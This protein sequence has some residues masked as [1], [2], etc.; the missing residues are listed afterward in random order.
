MFA[1]TTVLSR[2]RAYRILLGSALGLG[3]VGVTRVWWAGLGLWKDEAGIANNL[4]RSYLALTGHLTYE[5]VA[6]VGWLW[7][8][9][10][11]LEVLGADDRVIRLPSYLGAL[12]V[13]CL[14]TLIAHRVIGRAGAVVVAGLLAWSPTLLVYSG[15]LKQYTW[16]A[17]VALALLLLGAWAHQAIRWTRPISRRG[18]LASVAWVAATGVAVFVSYSAILVTAAVTAAVV[19]MHALRRSWA[20]VAWQAALSV[21]AGLAAA[22]LVARR[23]R[24]A[25]YPGQTDYFEG[26][27][28][29]EGASLRE[30]LAWPPYLWR[31]FV[32]AP[33][34]WQLSAL[35]LLLMVAGVVALRRRRPLWAAMLASVFVVAFGGAAARG[36]PMTSRPAIYLIAPTVLLVVAGLDGLVRAYA[37][38]R[39]R[40]R[41]VVATVA[42]VAVL[43]GVAVMV[44]PVYGTVRKEI[45]APQGKEAL[46][47]ALR[48]ISGQVREGDL[49]LVY[50]FGK[51]VET[52]YRPRMDIGENVVYVRLCQPE[53]PSENR[54]ALWERI[55]QAKR[56]FY[57]QGRLNATTRRD[58]FDVS[59]QALAAIGTVVERHDAPRDRIGPHSW[60]LVE[61]TH[62]SPAPTSAAEP[63][64]E[65]N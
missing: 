34:R 23:H 55:N 12:A 19:G 43:V 46:R 54:L 63:C 33:M 24:F 45:A 48:D 22:F 25:F 35:T 13:L 8:E 20:D 64:L 6:P 5:Q 56:V 3:I 29:P 30:F 14:S 38:V 28:A 44:R 16:E 49:V 21:P 50:Y 41:G 51:A 53:S 40:G 1:R 26:G 39:H 7:L 42:L 32:D 36:Y 57:V 11:I 27:T 17:G 2:D 65:T 18:M 9:K 52:W 31:Q 47:D 58:N 4:N 15:E 60:A 61:I 62:P 37:V 10:A 59:V